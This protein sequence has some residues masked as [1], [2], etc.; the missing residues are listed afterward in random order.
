MVGIKESLEE[1]RGRWL[2]F[3]CPGCLEG[4]KRKHILGSR[5]ECQNLA[6]RARRKHLKA[7]EYYGVSGKVTQGKWWPLG[8]RPALASPVRGQHRTREPSVAAG[9]LAALCM[10][11]PWSEGARALSQAHWGLGASAD[12]WGPFG[13][14]SLQELPRG[15]EQTFSR[16]VQ[17]AGRQVKEGPVSIQ[18]E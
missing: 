15:L 3:L 10:G 14:A 12:D 4:R 7:L 1:C 9:A 13:E 11:W 5:T 2:G 18:Q 6:H 16:A 17:Q 8:V